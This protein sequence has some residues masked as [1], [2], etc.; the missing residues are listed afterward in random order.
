M[1]LCWL[2]AW[3]AFLFIAIFHQYFS[4]FCTAFIFG[5]GFSASWF[6][7]SG[8]WR[9]I[10]ILVFRLPIF[11]AG[12]FIVLYAQGKPSSFFMNFSGL[13]RWLEGPKDALQW[14]FL[15]LLLL[16]MYIVWK[17]G[18]SLALH[19]LN[20]ETVYNRFDLGISAFFVL[21]IIKTLMAVKGGIIISQLKA[22]WLFIPYFI[23]GLLAIGLIRNGNA[24]EKDYVPGFQKMGVILSFTVVILLLGICISLLFYSHLTTG[25]EHLSVV[26]KQGAAPLVPVF[27]AVIRFLFGPRQ[28]AGQGETGSFGAHEPDLSSL[29]E[30]GKHPGIMEEI[31][32][33]ASGGFIAILLIAGVCF[34]A[35]LLWKYLLTKTTPVAKEKIR[36]HSVLAWILA[37]KNIMGICRKKIVRLIKGHVSGMELYA[38]LLTWGRH[39]GIS[40]GRVETPLEY[41]RRLMELFPVL[42][43]EIDLIIDLFQNEVYG[44]K[45]LN[46]EE[47]T[48]GRNAWR[49]LR[50]PAYFPLRI[51]T[52]FLSPSPP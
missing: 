52:W 3:A 35:W 40:R 7:R 49:K 27:I 31:L 12:L 29:A 2:Y 41:G 19:P 13:L 45:V 18:S 37:L 47:L 30:S 14:L 4:F 22:P 50:R 5:L 24:V 10:Q 42:K 26:L 36:R 15:I 17:R 23:F 16:L 28:H 32:K 33:W 38:S 48:T 8:G 1:E 46:A 44:E 21:L 9:R 34:G 6:H 39:S 43:D 25:A 11:V 20:E 51:K